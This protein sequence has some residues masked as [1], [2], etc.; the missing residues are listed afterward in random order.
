MSIINSKTNV[1]K[2]YS[3]DKNL[4]IRASLH[5][6][7]ST[8]K[9]GLVPWLFEFYQFLQNYNILELG[10]GNGNQWENRIEDL[11]NG[12]KLI[13]TDFS[14]GMIK[15]AK[16]KYSKYNNVAFE[17]M[18]IQDIKYPDNTFDAV[19]A[20][21][22]L[23]HVPDLSKALSEVYRVLKKDGKFYCTTIGIGGINLFFAK[24]RE[25]S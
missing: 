3:N 13:L 23:Y 5:I 7:Y 8:N 11:P 24:C 4:S 6:K 15:S 9:K 14:D 19:I 21:H 2:Q 18:D 10:C 22:M 25:T 20:N 12:C 1:E 16:N 17:Q